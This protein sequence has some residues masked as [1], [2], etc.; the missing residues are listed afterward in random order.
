MD[1]LI[2]LWIVL[3]G[4]AIG[5]VIG[6]AF[7][8]VTQRLLINSDP[9]PIVSMPMLASTTAIVFGLLAWRVGA[10]LDVVAYG[11]LT[12][13]GVPLAAVDLVEYR[14]PRPLLSALYVI[15]VG[16][17]GL[18]AALEHDLGSLIRA[19]SGMAALLAFYLVMALLSN[20]GVGAGDVRLAG[21]LG[22]AMAWRGWTTLM[23]GALLGLVYA[24]VIAAITLAR[25][26]S[27]G[28]IRISLGPAMI[29]GALTVVLIPIG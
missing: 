29:G 14:L 13:V 22:L 28:E 26:R 9:H 15:L 7:A 6:T 3:S 24:A 20:G 11:C 18:E 4:A 19:V 27:T 23:T 12:A 5:A 25:Q 1:I 21:A 2:G 17:F 10:H 8:P 16:L